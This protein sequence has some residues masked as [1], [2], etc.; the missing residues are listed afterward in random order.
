M[1]NTTKTMINEN[2][3]PNKQLHTTQSSNDNVLS[4]LEQFIQF[5]SNSTVH[6]KAITLVKG[7]KSQI[8]SSKSIDLPS[9]YLQHLIALI[10]IDMTNTSNLNSGSQMNT[11]AMLISLTVAMKCSSNIRKY[12]DKLL[13]IATNHADKLNYQKY[14]LMILEALMNTRTYEELSSQTDQV[15]YCFEVF[16]TQRLIFTRDADLRAQLIKVITRFFR[17]NQSSTSLTQLNQV[18]LHTPISISDATKYTLMK[19]IVNT[20]KNYIKGM[21]IIHSDQS[22]TGVSPM[23]GSDSEGVLKFLVAI[24]QVFPFDYVNDI[25]SELVKLINY[26]SSSKVLNQTLLVI[27][28]GLMTKPFGVELLEE[29]A[30]AMIELDLQLQT[31]EVNV[32][33]IAT[34]MKTLCTVV[35]CIGKK[36]KKDTVVA[37]RYVPAVI[38]KLCQMIKS[39]NF[40]DDKL[41]TSESDLLNNP[42]IF[43]QGANTNETSTMNPSTI[44]KKTL[45]YLHQTF[46]SS[47]NNLITRVFTVG[48][49]DIIKS[50]MIPN[51]DDNNT[52]TLNDLDLDDQSPK[53]LSSTIGLIVKELLYIVDPSFMDMRT[54]YNLLFSFI[55][56][57]APYPRLFKPFIDT[58]F[59]T[60]KEK[61]DDYVEYTKRSSLRSKFEDQCLTA[62]KEFYAKCFNLFPGS[63]LSQYIRLDLISFDLESSDYV[64]SS[65]VW[66][67]P[68]V[69][70]F[71]KGIGEIQSV[72]DYTE[73]F[74]DSIKQL[75]IKIE[76]LK[77]DVNP[78]E[79]TKGESLINMMQIDGEM[80]DERYEDSSNKH[81]KLI[82][83][84]RYQLMLT[85]IFSLLP[86]FI[87]IKEKE[88][89]AE[90]DEIFSY[91]DAMSLIIEDTSDSSMQKIVFKTMQKTLESIIHYPNLLSHFQVRGEEFFVSTLKNLTSMI[92][93]GSKSYGM[94]LNDESLQRIAMTTLTLLCKILS[95]DTVIAAIIKQIDCFSKSVAEYS[96]FN[97][98]T[99]KEDNESITAQLNMS[100]DAPS[101]PLSKFKGLKQMALRVQIIIFLFRGLNYNQELFEVLLNFSN[102]FFFSY[103]DAVL[104][105]QNPLRLYSSDD[106]KSIIKSLVD[107]F[108]LLLAKSTPE[109]GILIFS[110]LWNGNG[111]R[112]L[113]SKQKI[114]L[115]AFAMKIVMKDFLSK[116]TKSLDNLK[117]NFAT[118]PIVI[119]IINLTKDIN[120]K[121]RNQAFDLIAELSDFM[122]ECGIFGDWVKLLMAFLVSK[123]SFLISGVINTLARVFWQ[124][125]RELAL[126]CQTAETVLLLLKDGVSEVTKSLFLFIRVLVYV[127]SGQNKEIVIQRDPNNNNN[128]TVY[129]LKN[130]AKMFVPLILTEK[131]NDFKVKI[132][133]LIKCLILKLGFE[134]VKS[135][136]GKDNEALVVYIGKHVIRRGEKYLTEEEIYYRQGQGAGGHGVVNQFQGQR[137]CKD[138]IAFDDNDLDYDEEE[139]FINQEFKKDNKK[140][141][142]YDDDFENIER[143][144]FDEDEHIKGGNKQEPKEEDEV[145]KLFNVSD[146]ELKNH[147]YMNP[148][149]TNDSKKPNKHSN[150]V[151]S[152]DE[153]FFD[154]KK[155]KLIIKDVGNDKDN[156]AKKGTTIT[157]DHAAPHLLKRKRKQD[158]GFDEEYEDNSNTKPLNKNEKQESDL[159]V[160]KRFK[161]SKKDILALNLNE[162]KQVKSGEVKKSHF[163][164]FTGEEYKSSKGKGDLLLKGKYE[165]FAYIQLNPKAALDKNNKDNLKVFENVM[166]GKK[167]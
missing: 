19:N 162:T 43:N 48:T 24:I 54:S 71:L 123:D 94:K 138:N 122:I 156:K 26:C 140:H 101:Q 103:A 86:S 99:I 104:K 126:L 11:E 50:S 78:S 98:S 108:I 44:K 33:L 125:R 82:K 76:L 34:Y 45:E 147:F 52:D 152:D 62:F 96:L 22:N 145:A 55:E 73:Y 16:T 149:L 90:L 39:E 164:K 15:C 129:S 30:D 58:V 25:I 70:R 88:Q 89:T 127:I 83:I 153:V 5:N 121:V 143:L 167:K 142:D 141:I 27:E 6:K 12:T 36:D 97:P 47:I 166:R 110:E 158:L 7:I 31:E 69:S 106:F 84:G 60:V 37:L 59:E 113:S 130:F 53:D 66:V 28:M 40:D 41:L 68:F 87:N 112:V 56:K 102:T 65:Y 139:E 46:F 134:E 118:V 74:S 111:M 10:T 32:G 137:D 133:N 14:V 9:A 42:A 64:E 67:I 144:L 131:N 8:G 57:L 51:S 77:K 135:I 120:K 105:Q 124:E 20:L 115:F 75:I 136:V 161:A 109:K 95:T 157:T 154:K 128:S 160:L 93:N 116:E 100:I 72:V 114:K 61:F 35:T 79:L 159:E 107:L 151:D 117:S 21:H 23:T 150:D 119:E 1:S 148:Y 18:R 13:E 17:Q 63:Y 3:E 132:R 155:Q 81:T 4:R 91:I 165:P 38:G 49:I 29:L 85:Q 92:T 163:V 146:F 2:N 80:M